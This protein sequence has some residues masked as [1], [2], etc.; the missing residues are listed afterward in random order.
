MDRLKPAF[1]LSDLDVDNTCGSP[2][3]NHADVTPARSALR[4]NP[5]PHVASAPRFGS[6]VLAKFPYLPAWPALV[7]DPV[8]TPLQQKRSPR[9]SVA[10]EFFGTH[11]FAFV[12]NADIQPFVARQTRHRGVHNAT[13]EAEQYILQHGKQVAMFNLGKPKR[14]VTFATTAEFI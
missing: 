10:V 8:G 5:Q 3:T 2:S 6:V 13:M 12:R 4:K 14:R 11:K 9:D 1:R 7:V